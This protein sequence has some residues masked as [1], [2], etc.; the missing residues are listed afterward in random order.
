MPTYGIEPPEP[1]HGILD[2]EAMDRIYSSALNVRDECGMGLSD[3]DVIRLVNVALR[4]YRR[5]DSLLGI[6]LAFRGNR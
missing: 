4:E 6:C 2:A 1:P 5:D 3:M